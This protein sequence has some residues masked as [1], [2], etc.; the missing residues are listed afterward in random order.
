[1]SLVSEFQILLN[2]SSAYISL[3]GDCA[4]KPEETKL[5][6]SGVNNGSSP[7]AMDIS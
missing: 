3:L 5:V 6:D 1:V 4:K 2:T 7:K